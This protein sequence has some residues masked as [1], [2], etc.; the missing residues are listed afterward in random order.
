MNQRLSGTKSLSKYGNHLSKWISKRVDTHEIPWISIAFELPLFSLFTRCIVGYGKDT[1][2][3]E[4]KWVGDNILSVFSA[5]VS[6][7]YP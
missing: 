7:I 4:V 2:F 1:Y 5:F 3:W 6:L